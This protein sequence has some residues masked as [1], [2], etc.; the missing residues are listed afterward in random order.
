MAASHTG[1]PAA[2][3]VFCGGAG[4]SFRAEARVVPDQNACAWFFGAHH[5]TGDC[6]HYGANVLE[7]EVFGDD[8]APAV[9]AK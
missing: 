8:G 5:V 7:R 4:K 3:I 9:G 1:M 2:E 6:V